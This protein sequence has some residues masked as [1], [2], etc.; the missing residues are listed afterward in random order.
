METEENTPTQTPFEWI[1][2]EARVK[3]WSSA[4]TT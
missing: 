3:A 1:G 2:G 4:S